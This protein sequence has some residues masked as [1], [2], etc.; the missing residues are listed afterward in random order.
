MKILI[1]DHLFH[2]RTKSNHFFV[3]VLEQFFDIEHTYVDPKD[4]ENLTT[5][6]VGGDVDM[7]L[8]W[9]MDFL[10][11]LFLA[12]GIRTV[13]VPMY[14]GSGLMP[15]LHWLWSRHAYF[16]NFSRRLHE[17]VR[18]LGISS[19]LLKYYPKPPAEMPNLDFNTLRIFLWQ[20]RPEEGINLHLVERMFE[21]APKDVHIHDD[22]D[23]A[24][25]D[26]SHY[27]RPQDTSYALTVS[28]WFK[29]RADYERVLDACNIFMAPRETEGI[30]LSFLEAMAK[31][32]VV[33]AADRPTHDEY[34]A[35]WINGVLYNPHAPGHVELHGRGKALSE[36]AWRSCVEGYASWQKTMPKL[37]AF[38][39][40]V[41]PL[42]PMEDIPTE[43]L[44]RS[45][46]RAY[47]GGAE[48]YRAYLIAWIDLIE[49][50]S[51]VGLQGLVNEAGDYE[52]EKLKEMQAAKINLA[53][54]LAQNRLQFNT[55]E[56]KKHLEEGK[57]RLQD[58]VAWLS[59]QSLAFRARLNVSL[60]LPKKM[61]V[62]FHLANLEAPVLVCSALNGHTLAFLRLANGKETVEF[63]IP[64]Q[65]LL[66]E[67]IFRFQYGPSDIGRPLPVGILGIEMIAFE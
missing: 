36:M 28:K 63:A 6:K 64:P 52:P 18:R 20:R 35:N 17:R 48:T 40:S 54:L 67:N 58:S 9:Q 43:T 23:N 66:Q 3:K 11:P 44:A 65:A 50:M 56:H 32:K 21:G 61:R 8:L 10:A 62:T 53:P 30:G 1:I 38:L 12:R 22:A 57:L 14:D 7:V 13:V 59:G 42:P 24:D 26:T 27:L 34:I 2:K 16:V 31:G 33:I 46:V 51:G 41:P 29:K 5:T 47:M 19:H 4:F 39:Q 45:L 37:I 60:G 49:R 55:G 25:L 15:D